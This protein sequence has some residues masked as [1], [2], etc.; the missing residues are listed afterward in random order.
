MATIAVN[1]A[2]TI[3]PTT[4]AEVVD[5]VRSAY[6]AR[7]A[8]YPLGGGTA[9]DYGIAPTQPG[10][11]LDLTGLNRVVDYTPRDMTIVVEAGMR[12]SEL[13][14]TLASEGQQ[15]PI[16]VP[17]AGEATLGGV[18]ATNWSG[19]RRFGHGTI[20]DYI[21]G[22]NAVDGRGTAFKGGGR[23]VKNVAGYDFCKLLTGSLG[24]L[25]VI[26]QVALKV[27]PKLECMATV[28]GDY[29]DLAAAD[30]ALERLAILETPAAAIELLVGEAWGLAPSN[31]GPQS[32]GRNQIAVLLEGSEQEVSWLTSRV[33]EQ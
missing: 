16:D 31:G 9:Q 22:V 3:T 27:K 24:T 21:I 32:N 7:R 11:A 4:Q 6:E 14:A 10:D 5:A 20:R 13:A 26:T 15:L 1:S 33:G 2:E 17:R 30:R 12:M 28:V 23:V 29:E 18:I 19:P 8:I 25:A